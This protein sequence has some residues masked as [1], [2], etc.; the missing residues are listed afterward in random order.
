[1]ALS[2][3]YSRGFAGCYSEWG[4]KK[5]RRDRTAN[6]TRLNADGS[7]RCD[8][9]DR[10]RDYA[11]KWP[12]K[13][14]QDAWRWATAYDT[15]AIPRAQPRDTLSRS[16]RICVASAKP[17]VSPVIIGVAKKPRVTWLALQVRVSLSL[18]TVTFEYCVKVVIF[19][20]VTFKKC[21]K[22]LC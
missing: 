17:G 15:R 16:P 1:M 13:P 14:C 10:A 12:K 21:T 3:S 7:A 5:T 9:D 2:Y 6:Q 19:E 18:P 22:F 4:E 11:I 20:V 8:R